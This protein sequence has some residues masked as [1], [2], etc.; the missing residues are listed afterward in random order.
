MTNRL[1]RL[2]EVITLTGKSRS[3]IYADISALK[4][5]KPISIGSRSVAWQLT[6]VEQWIQSR[7]DQSIPT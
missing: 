3:S 7:I 1:I 6:A 5:P 4:F 2:K